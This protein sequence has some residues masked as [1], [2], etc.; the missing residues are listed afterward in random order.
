[1]FTIDKLL[2]TTR[3]GKHLGQ[4]ELLSYQPDQNLCV[5]KHLQAYVDQT[6]ELR[7]EFSDQLLLGYQKPHKPVSTNTIARWIKVVIAKAG[8]DTD[9]YKAHSTRAAVT[10]AAK[11]KQVPIDTILSAAGWTNENTFSRFYNKPFKDNELL[12]AVQ[13]GQ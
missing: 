7:E 11:G 1:M 4:I 5:V 10:S 8:I 6:S 13:D 3:P 9:V 2:K 12:N